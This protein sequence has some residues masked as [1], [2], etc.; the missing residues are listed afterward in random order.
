M[1]EYQR[2]YSS[3]LNIQGNENNAQSALS[4][5]GFVSDEDMQLLLQ[6][7]MER[8]DQ[9]ERTMSVSIRYHLHTAI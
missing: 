2:A 4:Q 7:V 6:A 9:L 8:M 3:S 5:H 1:N